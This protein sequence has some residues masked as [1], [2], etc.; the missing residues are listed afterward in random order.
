MKNISS[1]VSADIVLILHLTGG[2]TR[3]ETLRDCD[4][5]LSGLAA[6]ESF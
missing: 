4:V 2:T 5:T 1:I 3:L 6:C